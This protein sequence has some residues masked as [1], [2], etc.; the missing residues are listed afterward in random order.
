MKKTGKT[1]AKITALALTLCI[2]FGA[3]PVITASAAQL[4]SLTF[5]YDSKFGLVREKANNSYAE[6]GSSTLIYVFPEEGCLIDTVTI[7]DVTNDR[8]V[9]AS[10]APVFEGGTGYTFTMPNGDVEVT[11]TFKADNANGYYMVNYVYVGEGYATFYKNGIREPFY[12]A[13]AGDR[14]S[15]KEPVPGDGY[16]YDK[17][18]AE[19]F[20]TTADGSVNNI[21]VDQNFYMPESDITITITFT[22]ANSI[23][24]VTSGGTAVSCYNT[25]GFVFD[26]DHYQMTSSDPDRPIAVVGTS[27]ENHLNEFKFRV[28]SASGETLPYGYWSNNTMAYASFTMPAEAVTAYVTFLKESY[29]VACSADN[30]TLGYTAANG[31]RAGA[32]ITLELTPDEGYGTKELYYTYTPEVGMD[33]VRVD[34]D[35]A[36]PKFRMPEADVNV[37]AVFAPIWTV[38]WLDGD[39]RLLD[40]KTFVEGTPIPETDMIPTKE[41]T[42]ECE[43]AFA[44]WSAPAYYSGNLIVFR[45]VFDSIYTVSIGGGTAEPKKAKAGTLITLTPDE[46][47]SGMYH[48]GWQI[49]SGDIEVTGNTF[50]MP[51]SHVSLYAKYELKKS[52]DLNF[53]FSDEKGYVGKPFA[54]SG[55]LTE[56]GELLDVGGTVTITFSSGTPDEEGAVS[57]TVPVES[58]VFS[59]EV[60]ALTAG[61]DRVWLEYSG[62]G[63]YGDAMSMTMI[64]LYDVVAATMAPSLDEGNVKR[65]YNAGDALDT[66]NLYIRLYWADGSDET[67]P[68][69]GE[70]VSGFDS[71]KAGWQTLTVTCPYSTDDELNY[72]VYV[73]GVCLGDVNNDRR[74]DIRDVSA[75]QRHLAEYTLLNDAQLLAADIDRDGNVT[76]DDATALQMFLAEYESDF[77]VGTIL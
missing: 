72:D 4:R 56:N 31:T 35:P 12:T 1:L 22:E 34:I 14:L 37:K 17:F 73:N 6:V 70:M 57:Y 23:N 26:I 49:V 5:N 47:L 51:A 27:D 55:D 19:D 69:T 28:Q 76:I 43:Y 29:D 20:Y 2:I 13:K 21:R 32:E 18:P 8:A 3:F 64:D 52:V 36:N 40:I 68:V 9:E 42:W 53:D 67:V 59:L 65:Y 46:P 39:G 58:G 7:M 50:V 41:S 44:G 16:I 62:Y 25:F 74:I 30:G 54:V 60:S 33:E 63:E 66:T 77:P 45:P 38:E 61:N 75:I 48:S 24:I 15:Y 10:S 71:L 11:A